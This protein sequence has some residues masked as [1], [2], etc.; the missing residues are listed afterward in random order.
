M[1]SFQKEL[2][3]ARKKH[4]DASGD[5]GQMTLE[6]IMNGIRKYSKPE[7]VKVA[8]FSNFLRQFLKLMAE[9]NIIYY[10]VKDQIYAFFGV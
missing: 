9:A 8:L 6:E 2:E 5:R 1:L 7:T 10:S 3:A 4:G